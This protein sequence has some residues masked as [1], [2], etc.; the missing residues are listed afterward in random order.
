MSCGRGCRPEAGGSEFRRPEFRKGGHK[1]A[2][3]LLAPGLFWF[4][5]VG[6][7]RIV[8]SPGYA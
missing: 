2:P 6:V 3:G 7:M 1:K 8:F 5:S 4:S